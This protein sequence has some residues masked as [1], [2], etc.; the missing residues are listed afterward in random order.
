MVPEF[1][2]Y[3]NLMSEKLPPG[4]KFLVTNFEVGGSFGMSVGGGGDCH[5]VEVTSIL[6]LLVT[7]GMSFEEVCD[8]LY[9]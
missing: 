9:T 5:E 1:P 3:S 2:H 8:E 6:E 4:G 7:F